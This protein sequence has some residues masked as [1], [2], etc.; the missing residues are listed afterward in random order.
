MLPFFKATEWEGA[1]FVQ[2]MII[3]T[4]GVS[5]RGSCTQRY[6][7]LVGRELVNATT[8]NISYCLPTE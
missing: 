3:R 1:K 8:G 4:N 5:Q 7:W 2:R 6:F